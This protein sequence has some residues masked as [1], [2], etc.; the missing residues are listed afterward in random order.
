MGEQNFKYIIHLKAGDAVNIN[1]VPYELFGDADVGGDTRPDQ[2][3]IEFNWQEVKN[4][5]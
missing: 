1:G 5:D 4:E 3:G 2:V